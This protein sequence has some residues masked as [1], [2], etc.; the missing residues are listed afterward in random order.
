LH[1]SL[2]IVVQ[3]TFL[4]DTVG[5]ENIKHGDVNEQRVTYHYVC[6]YLNFDQAQ[7]NVDL[8]VS[9]HLSDVVCASVS[10]EEVQTDRSN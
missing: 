2:K 4:A 6:R 7:M 10:E 8:Q 5:G 1:F 9:D 3:L